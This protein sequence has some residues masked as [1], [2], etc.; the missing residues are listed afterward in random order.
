M[1]CSSKRKKKNLW[2]FHCGKQLDKLKKLFFFS[3][4]SNHCV[5]LKTVHLI[6]RKL[7]KEMLMVTKFIKY[8]FF[9]NCLP[10]K[11]NEKIKIEKSNPNLLK[12]SLLVC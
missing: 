8:D 7:K 3:S 10:F 5:H 1:D 9:N 6:R 2:I 12:F 4:F 11:Y